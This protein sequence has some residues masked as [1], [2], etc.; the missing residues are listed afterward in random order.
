MN[1]RSLLPLGEKRGDVV[2]SDPF[3]SLQR[4]IDRVFQEFTRGFSGQ[5]PGAFLPRTDVV[6][7]DGHLE[8]TAEL[9]G[10]EDKDVEVTLVDNILTVRGEKKAERE[11]K[12]GVRRVVERSYGAFT[13][14]IELPPGVKPEDIKAT[15][16]KGVLT[17]TL[18][19]P[20]AA[21]VQARR[22]DVQSVA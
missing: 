17:V 4:E 20:A 11:D 8:I 9:P 19:K 16:A 5:A 7:R 15:M 3:S 2:G 18:P 22:I 14:A 12:D 1:L 6:E 21:E 10:L 13:R